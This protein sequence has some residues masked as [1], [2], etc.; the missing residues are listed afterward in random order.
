MFK[1]LVFLLSFGFVWS[2]PLLVS[3]NVFH[4][5][6]YLLE[7]NLGRRSL[8]ADSIFESWLDVRTLGEELSDVFQPK[9][10]IREPVTSTSPQLQKFPTQGGYY[11]LDPT[12]Q[13][14]VMHY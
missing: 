6:G 11:V 9:I 8:N 5:L 12:T 3:D 13:T 1:L 7:A 2:F 10:S 14:V 4:N